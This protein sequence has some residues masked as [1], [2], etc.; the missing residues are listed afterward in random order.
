MLRGKGGGEEGRGV[1]I[2]F[3]SGKYNVRSYVVQG[4]KKRCQ[5]LGSLTPLL[6]VV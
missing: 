5:L 2:C 6:V 4:V 3:F 1:S